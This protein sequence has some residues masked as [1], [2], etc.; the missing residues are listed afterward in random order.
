MCS[1][2]KQLW[3]FFIFLLRQKPVKDHCVKFPAA[4]PAVRLVLYGPCKR[5]YAKQYSL[6]SQCQFI[7]MAVIICNKIR[8]S[9]PV[10][11]QS[12]CQETQDQIHPVRFPE[13]VGK[14]SPYDSRTM[15]FEPAQRQTVEGFNAVLSMIIF[16][17]PVQD[18]A[19]LC[20]MRR[21]LDFY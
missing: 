7:G 11:H 10:E 6:Q 8:T 13:A 18:H 2:T 14:L 5:R 1:S 16:Q 3:S 15:T 17:L 12:R 9:D 19:C 21:K 20:I 4:L